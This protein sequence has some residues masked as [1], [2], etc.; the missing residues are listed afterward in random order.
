[1]LRPYPEKVSQYNL[2]P[3]E[4]ELDKDDNILS[5][6]AQLKRTKSID[7]QFKH[8]Y[9]TLKYSLIE[10]SWT[11]TKFAMKYC[12]CK[13]DTYT[14][15]VKI[16]DSNNWDEPSNDFWECQTCTLHN[17]FGLNECAACESENNEFIKEEA[18]Y[19]AMHGWSED[20]SG[21]HV[22]RVCVYAMHKKTSVSR[23]ICCA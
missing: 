16:F 4:Y 9:H 15:T 14:P 3:D 11:L 7:I 20:G 22:R 17:S 13:Q 23:M 6:R 1:M 10:L 2:I 18:A 5:Q 21:E 19:A 12:M 8:T